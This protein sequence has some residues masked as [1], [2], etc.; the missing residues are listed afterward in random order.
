[1]R[2]C[3]LEVKAGAIGHNQ[4]VPRCRSPPE[5]EASSSGIQ[6][7]QRLAVIGIGITHGEV[8][9]DCAIGTVFVS[10]AL[11]KTDPLGWSVHHFQIEDR[12][13]IRSRK[14]GEAVGVGGDH[15][16]G[17][18]ACGSRGR[19]EAEAAPIEADPGRQGA[20]IGEGGAIAQ[21]LTK[22]GIAEGVEIK[23]VAVRAVAV[24]AAAHQRL[25][26]AG[27]ISHR[28][29]REIHQR[30]LAGEAAAVAA[31]PIEGG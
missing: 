31:T 10:A 15:P 22:V 27:G 1:M 8:A 16:D 5:G 18:C 4:A 23:G 25:L 3:G 28:C 26:Q 30:G 29:D 20:A 6:Q 14:A 17:V 7:D 12:T 13:W 11:R 2:R 9:H 24:D 19:I 21:S